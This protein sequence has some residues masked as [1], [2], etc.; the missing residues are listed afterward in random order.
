M[1][2]VQVSVLVMV[3][4]KSKRARFIFR[5][6]G[7]PPL[8]TPPL[9]ASAMSAVALAKAELP[10]WLPPSREALRRDLAGALA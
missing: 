8:G 10:D 7:L 9:K 2:G 3:P 4:S 6:E 1:N 5:S